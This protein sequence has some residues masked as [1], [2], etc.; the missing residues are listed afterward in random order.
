M[1]QEDRIYTSKV[2]CIQHYHGNII[3]SNHGN[4]NQPNKDLEILQKTPS[5]WP[6][7]YSSSI[8]DKDWKIHQAYSHWRSYH[9]SASWG[10]I[11][12]APENP[13]KNPPAIWYWGGLLNRFPLSREAWASQTLLHTE[14]SFV[15]IIESNQIEFTMYRLIWNSKRKDVRLLF[16]INRCMVNTIWFRFDLTQFGKDFCEPLSGMEK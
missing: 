10:T 13:C 15:N 4:R 9:L 14:K 8:Y 12:S 3:D 5:G 16:R 7:S 2:I 1:N 11:C 6:F